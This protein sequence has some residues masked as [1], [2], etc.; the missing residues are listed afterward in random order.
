MWLMQPRLTKFWKVAKQ[1]LR[2]KQK[3]FQ[4][5][6]SYSIDTTKTTNT[7]QKGQDSAEPTPDVEITNPLRMLRDQFDPGKLK[8]SLDLLVGDSSSVKPSNKSF[9]DETSCSCTPLTD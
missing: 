1:C 7:K 3:S 2:K 9:E 8:Q 6:H 4:K 5:N